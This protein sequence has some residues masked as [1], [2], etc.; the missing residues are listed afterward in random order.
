MDLLKV[1]IWN[2]LRIRKLLRPN[3]FE[4]PFSYNVLTYNESIN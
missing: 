3:L 1:C 4:A 2:I